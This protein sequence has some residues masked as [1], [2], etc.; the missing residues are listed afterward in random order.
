MVLLQPGLN[1]AVGL[2]DIH[3]AALAGR[4]T[5]PGPESSVPVRLYTGR[6]KLEVF[7]G[8]RIL[9]L[10]LRLDSILLMRL[11]VFWM[12]GN[13]YVSQMGNLLISK[14]RRCPEAYTIKKEFTSSLYLYLN[15]FTRDRNCNVRKRRSKERHVLIKNTH[16]K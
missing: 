3:L 15:D 13:V 1:S 14:Q 11:H 16:F 9:L 2:S 6:R 8:G 5:Y 4:C 10:M 7:L 12:C